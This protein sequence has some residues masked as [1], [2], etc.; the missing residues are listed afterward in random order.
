MY[1]EIIIN[2][3]SDKII[4]SGFL[5]VICCH[6]VEKNLYIVTIC[7]RFVQ[8]TTVSF[9]AISILSIVGDPQTVIFSFKY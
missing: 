6:V 5:L 7:I 1:H 3:D 2:R 8:S 4:T 9:L